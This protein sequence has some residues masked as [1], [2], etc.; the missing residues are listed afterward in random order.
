MYEFNEDQFIKDFT[1]L[2]NNKFA[3]SVADAS[4]KEYYQTLGSLVSAYY[5]TNW[6]NTWKQYDDNLKK[7][8]YYFSIEFLPGK[9]LRSNL[10]NMGILEPVT[11]ALKKLGI[12]LADVA[13]VE[14]DMA[15]GNGGLG[16][17]ASC[18]MD[19]LA[20]CRLPGN[21]NG[22]RY[23]YGLFKQRIL[24][25]YQ[26]ELPNEW[27]NGGNVW[28][29]RR[30]SKSVDVRFGG[31]VYLREDERG[32]LEPVYENAR[33]VRAVPYDM[34]MVGYH[35]DCVNTLRLWE[36]EIPAE[37]ED[38]YRS[39]EDRRMLEDL[40]STLYPDDSTES[41]RRLRLSQEYFFVSAGIQSII[42]HYLKL[43]K[44]LSEISELVAIHINDTHPAMCIPE[45]MRLLID[46]NQMAWE[47]AWTITNQVMSYTNHTILAEALEK[48][49][50]ELLQ[51][52]Q[53]RI[54]QII[55]EIDRRFVAKSLD[56]YGWETIDK[57]RI[58]K[59]GQVQMAHLAIIGSHSTNGVAKLHTELLKKEVLKEF[60]SMFPERFNNKTNGIA[61]RRW[62]Q[63]AN[64]EMSQVLDDTIGT[65]WRQ[66]PDDLLLLRN[67]QDD[68]VVLDQLAQAKKTNKEHLAQYM[69]ETMGL[70]VP[71]DA[72]FD[73]QIKR[74]HAYKRQL[75]N[76]LHII[77]LYQE[78]KEKPTRPIAPR[79]FIFGA[80]AAP[81]YQ[82][83]KAVIKVINEVAN[84]V[85][86]DPAMKGKL[87]VAF[88][89]NYNVSLAELII[90]AAD[91]SE[92][93]SLASKEA[94]GTS[95]MKLMLNGAVTLATLD[96]ANIEIKDAVGADQIVVFG[97]NA[98]QVY[99][100]YSDQ[101]YSAQAFYND[102]PILKRAVDALVDG[103][104][105]NIVY[106]GHGIYDSLLKYN[107]EFFVLADFAAYVEAQE[108]INQLYLD[109]K[110]WQKVSLLNIAHAGRFSSDQTV[111]RYAEEIWQITPLDD[112]Y[113]GKRERH[114]NY[115]L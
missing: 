52:V 46:D 72:I 94:S 68:Q 66:N 49:P 103:T 8:T 73:V 58:I 36:S 75:L 62:S 98:E 112:K 39:I 111:Q 47:Q 2:L 21:G 63:L 87:A 108:K 33:I 114:D 51:S 88:L 25:G 28:E 105:P 30:E 7:Q 12:E 24:D 86:H 15:L 101:S 45:F 69:K 110:H 79:V 42:R 95:N 9:M 60:Y 100:Y 83:A 59:D 81:S 102:D 115:L 50:V 17:L 6:K 5:S 31:S 35:N 55:E 19:S 93:I 74:L 78:L 16:R 34:G 84:L 104:I 96:G 91:V 37:A 70:V 80:K 29:I 38:Q 10:L 106:E 67:F 13:A 22:I 89:E 40:T 43:G 77:A 26:V 90:P 107:D 11:Q 53:P 97:L 32:V 99:Q 65:S 48:W 54:Y 82:Y 61:Q 4:S 57:T 85:N 44:P 76:L 64:P 71:T 92:Q 41:G 113:R 27:L 23:Q 1:E 18:F 109:Q 56:S 14:P 20:S 3:I